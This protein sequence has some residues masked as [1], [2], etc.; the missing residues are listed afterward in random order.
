MWVGIMIYCPGRAEVKM[1]ADADAKVV[2]DE[3]EEEETEE[4]SER[5]RAMYLVPLRPVHGSQ[6][7]IAVPIGVGH[8]VVLVFIMCWVEH[9]APPNIS[10][11][12]PIVVRAC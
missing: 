2:I 1:E 7:V 5:D 8:Q 10:S 4:S 9:C 6:S 11:N 3:G 12:L